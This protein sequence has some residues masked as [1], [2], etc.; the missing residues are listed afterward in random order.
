[1]YLS[2]LPIYDTSLYVPGN[3]IVSTDVQA[4]SGIR[5][6]GA[7]LM[8]VFGGSSQLMDKKV[9]DVVGEAMSRFI[10]TAQ[11]KGAEAAVGITTDVNAFVD[12]DQVYIIAT[13]TGTPLM[14]KKKAALPI[15]PPAPT[16]QM[17]PQPVAAVP[18]T[19]P[20][21]A[22]APMM[23]QTGGRRRRVPKRKTAKR[24]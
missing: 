19:Q 23:A 16:Q 18:I 10:A 1:M 6:M 4:V 7:Q 9:K 13:I 15:V 5:D 2:T 11:T 3:I 20:M 12:K 21:M 24:R 22:S 8:G 14:D 17:L